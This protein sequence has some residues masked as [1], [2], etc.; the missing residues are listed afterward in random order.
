MSILRKTYLIPTLLFFIVAQNLS[1]QFYYGH[2][3]SFGKSRVQYNDF[4]WYFFR[5]ENFDTYFNQQGK[6]LAN[7]VSDYLTEEISRIESF[8]D[9]DLDNRIIFIIYNKLTDFRQSNIGLVTGKDDNN[10]G[11]VTRIIKNKVFIYFDGDHKSFEQQISAAIAEVVIN[12][13]LYG[14]EF[15]E[16]VTNSTLIHLP[17]WYLK[18]LIS[19]VSRKWD[20]EME[21]MVK[22]GIL[23]ERFDKFNQLTGND[24]I[25]AGHS[26]WKFIADTYGESVIPNILYL[27]KINKNTNSGFLYVLGFSVKDLSYDWM[28]YYQNM[29]DESAS[30]KE[31]PQTGKLLKRTNKKRVYDNIKISP[32][33]KYIAYVTNQSGQYKIWLYDN[34]TGKQK[35]LIRK[36]HKLDQIP[37][38]SYPVI[39]WHP[40]GQIL[41]FITEEEGGI[42]LNYYILE[43][44]ELTS[45]NLLFFEKVLDYSFKDDGF[46]IVLSAINRGQADI[47][48]HNISAGTNEQITNDIYDDFQP[49]FISDSREI[50]FISNRP[51]DTTNYYISGKPLYSKYLPNQIFKIDYSGK[52]GELNRISGHKFLNEEYPFK[53][54]T[55]QYVYL[56]DQ[57]GLINRYV[58]RIDSSVAFI[59]TSVHYRY[60]TRSY[61]ISN[62]KRNILDQDVSRHDGQYAQILFNDGR[63]NMYTGDL[64]TDRSTF[65][66]ILTDTEFRKK[67]TQELSEADSLKSIRKETIAIHDIQDDKIITSR[68]DTLVLEQRTIDIN[69][70]IFELEKINYYNEKFRNDNLSLVL[71]TSSFVRPPPRIY[72]TAFYT[73]YLASQIDFSFLNDSYQMFTGGQVYY[74]PGFNMLFKVGTNDLFEDY[75][76]IGGIR[77]S[78]DFDSNE[79]LFSFEDLKRRLDKRAIYHRQVFKQQVR[80]DNDNLEDILKVYSQTLDFTLRWPFSQVAAFEGSVNLRDDQNV[81]LATD[82][83]SLGKDGFTRIWGG[84]RLAYIFDNT[85]NLGINLYNGTRFKVFAEAYQQIN[86]EF[87]DLYS[88]GADFRHY[89]KIHRTLIWANRFATG[90]SFG[91]SRL[92]YYL[93]SVDN[94]NNFSGRVETFDKSIPIDYEQNYAWQ[95]LSTNMRGFTQNIRNGDRF[96]VA[97][98]ELRWPVVRYFANHPL[99]SSFLNNL[100]LAGFYDIGTAWSGLHPWSGVN[101]YDTEI[102]ENGPITVT[103]DSNREPIVMGYGAG[104]RAMLLGYWI[105][106]D[107][108]W[109]IE[110]NIVLPRIFYFSLSLDF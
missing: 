6:A 89:I 44:K 64:E 83:T 57:N 55:N 28:G 36:E 22:D 47:Y 77:L 45:R 31:M 39:A 73:N 63:Y 109:G 14:N 66:G 18:G 71:D 96:S 65:Q 32:Y 52:T 50:L 48:V 72:E 53:I 54:E 79:Y 81:Y 30:D 19:Y 91:N 9:Y 68:A 11:G 33:G 8:F 103:I 62:Y 16:N 87:S 24:A 106:L 78:A 90:A 56:S 29:F 88:I 93:G 34:Q 76:I 20:F 59:D 104:V 43:T 1:A 97:N 100:M 95:T 61:P 82:Q 107:W 51:E 40:S 3:M 21:N 23:N 67:L 25:Q 5:Y 60:Q 37:D 74:N 92:I 46:K 42:R 13:M 15:R 105:R 102:I 69:N 99:S 75:K 101:A 84:V 108:A 12:E 2:Q 86:G 26:F 98:T 4:Y 38:Y 58:A 80:D 94:W 10:T 110:N 49:K 35:M 7:Y 17:D 85:R 27:T 41:T 70:Y